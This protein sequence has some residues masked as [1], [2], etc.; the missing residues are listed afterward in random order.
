MYHGKVQKR[1]T[2]RAPSRQIVM[3]KRL[4]GPGT[5]IQELPALSEEQ[6]RALYARREIGHQE[7]DSAQPDGYRE[8]DPRGLHLPR[9]MMAGNEDMRG[10][11]DM[12]HNMNNVGHRQRTSWYQ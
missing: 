10:G 1:A 6:L 5:D 2:D 8:V 7:G 3:P 9:G 12:G 11:T 4:G